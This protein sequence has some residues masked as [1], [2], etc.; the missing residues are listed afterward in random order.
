MGCHKDK[1]GSG[2]GMWFGVCVC[3]NTHIF[4]LHCM[5]MH[6]AVY[7]ANLSFGGFLQVVSDDNVCEPLPW[8]HAHLQECGHT[9]RGELSEH[10]GCFGYKPQRRGISL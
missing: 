7:L 1:E 10:D 3:S 9:G 6:V 2:L 8:Q 5:F 4:C